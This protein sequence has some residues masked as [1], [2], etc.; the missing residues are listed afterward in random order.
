MEYKLISFEI[1]KQYVKNYAKEYIKSH[2]I[3]RHIPSDVS[4]DISGK[5][6]EV[7]E[8]VLNYVSTLEMDEIDES[9]LSLLYN[10]NSQASY[11][12]GCGFFYENYYDAIISDM[13]SELYSR[14]S[15]LNNLDEEDI[16]DGLY[17]YITEIEKEWIY[18]ILTEFTKENVIEILKDNKFCQ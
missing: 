11:V 12:S 4:W 13:E 1:W 7:K 10:G 17:D 3:F 9:F 6:E 2:K 14:L 5:V 18:D 16:D 8:N 15:Y